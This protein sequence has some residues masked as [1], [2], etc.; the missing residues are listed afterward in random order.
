MRKDT[1]LDTNFV[2]QVAAGLKLAFTGKVSDAWFG[3]NTPIASVAPESTTGRAFDYPVGQNLRI[4]PRQGEGTGGITYDNLR[5]LADNHDVTRLAI[6]T[7]KDQ[8][9]RQKWNIKYKDGRPD[10]SKI[11]E[12][13]A[14]FRYPDK[15][16]THQQ[17]LRMII[18][19]LLVI[20]ATA[21]Y[22]RMNRG[23]GV[24][25]IDLIDP[26]TI[27]RMI[28][29]G[30]R[31]PMV[32]SPAYQQI[33]KGV[34][35]VD[36]T[37]DELFYSNR[38][39]RTNKIY[40]YSPVEQM[41]MTINM[42]LRRQASQL[43]YFTSGTVPDAIME[44]PADWTPDNIKQFQL[45]W[46]SILSGDTAERRKARFV[47]SGA[48]YTATK[49]ELLKDDFDEWLAKIISF[50]FSISSQAL[51]KTMNRASA[52]VSVDTAEQEGLWPWLEHLRHLHNHI[53]EKYLGIE[54]V[55]FEW[56]DEKSIDPLLQAQIDNIYITAGVYDPA[57]VQHRMGLD[58]KEVVVATPSPIPT[59]KIAKSG[60]IEG[61]PID[62]DRKTVTDAEAELTKTITIELQKVAD[63]MAK[64]IVDTIGKADEITI[65]DTNLLPM[66]MLITEKAGFIFEDGMN[67][68]WDMIDFK[69]TR[70]M[71]TVVNDRAI[72]Y[73]EERGLELAKMSETTKAMLR[74]VVAQSLK[75]GHNTQELTKAIKESYAFS[76]VRA[77][78]I[79]ET[80]M[81]TADSAGNHQAYVESGVV[82]FHKSLL[83]NNENHGAWDIA[84]AEEGT[85]PLDK[86]FVSGH[87]HPAYHPRCRCVEIAVME[88]KTKEIE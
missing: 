28:D 6:E 65:P 60:L 11:D 38:N 26:A 61:K 41:I 32:P 15:I 48:K 33:L 27:N 4:T 24:Y 73:A 18:E 45:Y 25:S 78:M 63:D 85:I 22:P 77:Q 57:Y 16:N 70:E 54:G 1:P 5:A 86:A 3:P 58:I 69:P 19:D 68:A 39:P 72:A 80:E 17:W 20:D 23:G 49:T 67:E 2:K 30:G 79:A 29:A 66:I 87:L 52:E 53:I 13:H 34:P 44:V 82:K 21:I 43:E 14:F 7:K 35:A 56:I 10:D 51:T 9:S 42:A 64:A 81:C 40:G 83:G 12:I 74:P 55:S 47:P 84:N 76:K 8:I 88:N 37:V 75:E 62:R 36:Y 31:T 59:E 50:A 71:L 46:D